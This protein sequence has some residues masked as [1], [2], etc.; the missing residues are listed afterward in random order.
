MPLVGRPKL[1]TTLPKALPTDAVVALL[2]ALASDPEPH[3][4]SDWIERDRAPILTGLLAGLRADELLRANIGDIRRTD[5]GAVLHVHGKGGKDRR[6][7]VESIL[8]GR[9][10]ALPRQ[11]RH[12]IPDDGQTALLPAGGLA[13]WSPGRRCLSVPT[14]RA[15]PAAP[16]SIGS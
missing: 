1:A 7:P 6:I 10:R 4:V 8:G 3:R 2:A 16:C 11:P 9:P 15:S 14:V 12:P 5:D 13:F